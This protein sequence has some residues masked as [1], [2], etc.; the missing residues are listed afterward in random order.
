MHE[1]YFISPLTGTI[2][3]I[4]ILTSQFRTVTSVAIFRCTIPCLL[5]LF[6]V[7]LS[8]TI[9]LR[10]TKNYEKCLMVQVPTFLGVKKWTFYPPEEAGNLRKTSHAVKSMGSLQFL[11]A[12]SSLKPTSSL[13]SSLFSILGSSC[14]YLYAAQ[15]FAQLCHC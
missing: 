4:Y 14:Q 15:D 3:R 1:L 11:N 9:F 2:T 6:S 12:V 13:T 5:D 7:T 8:S 10:C